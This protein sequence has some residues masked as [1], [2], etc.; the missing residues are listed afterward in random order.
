[1]NN[2]DDQASKPSR[3]NPS[4]SPSTQKDPGRTS[5]FSDLKLGARPQSAKPPT[6]RE[7]RQPGGADTGDEVDESSIRTQFQVSLNKVSVNETREIVSH[8]FEISFLGY[9]RSPKPY[10]QQHYSPM[11]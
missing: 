5:S 8:L 3:Q 4:K 1:M 2:N 10:Q 6:L 11:S 9:E 7:R